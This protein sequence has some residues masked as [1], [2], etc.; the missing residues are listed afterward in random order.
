M[1]YTEDRGALTFL[2]SSVAGEGNKKRI[3]DRWEKVGTKLTEVNLSVQGYSIDM[4]IDNGLNGSSDRGISHP[5]LSL[6]I[7]SCTTRVFGIKSLMVGEHDPTEEVS[8]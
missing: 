5:C 8:T 7:Q 4:R 3:I 2:G 1:A 6:I